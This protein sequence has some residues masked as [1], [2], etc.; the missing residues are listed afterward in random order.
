M[1]IVNP[2]ISIDDRHN[3]NTQ[4]NPKGNSISSF[5]ENDIDNG[6]DL[7]YLYKDPDDED[8]DI[9]TELPPLKGDVVSESQKSKYS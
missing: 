1:D 4:P 3:K 6:N 7:D 8:Q 2:Y 9:V 5:D